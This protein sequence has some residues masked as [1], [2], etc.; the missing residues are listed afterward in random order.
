MSKS[1]TGG[2]NFDWPTADEN[3]WEATVDAALDAI[4]G[5]DHTGGGNGAPIPSS[6]IAANGVNGSNIRLNNNQELRARNAAGSADVNLLKL[7]T[8]NILQILLAMTM[9][10]TLGVTGATTLSSTLDV[11]GNTVLSA[12]LRLTSTETLTGS[13][14]ISVSTVGTIL[15]GASLAMTLAA[16]SAGQIKWVVNIASTVATVT[17]S[18]TSGANTVSLRQQGFCAFVYYNSEWRALPGPGCI[19]T[20]DTETLT[21]SGAISLNLSRTVLNGSSLAMTLADG[22][23]GQIKH[24]VNI[25]S[26]AATITP[27]TTSGANVVS[28]GQHGAAIFVF[29]SGEWRAFLAGSSS[30]I[31]DDSQ[32][33]SGAGTWNGWSALVIATGTTYTITTPAGYDGQT[34]MFRN[35]AS[36]NVTF[37]GAVAATGTYYL[38]SYLN[39]GWR[40]V[41]LT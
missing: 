7:N 24:V 10:S 37:G 40:R 31:T 35:Q 22:S 14:A 36:G 38:Y 21:G 19:V 3:D 13:G 20:D 5:H 26:T 15:N 23:E 12:L 1:Y 30:H 16:G 18:A 8:S 33:F 28:L 17:P 2:L 4:S 41:A 32:S 29:E 25:A 27:A 6:G 11:T 34:V 9:D 39:A